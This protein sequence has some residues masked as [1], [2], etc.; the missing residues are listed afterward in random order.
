MNQMYEQK[1]LKYKAKYLQLKAELE[2]GLSMPKMSMPSFGTKVPE[3][4]EVA[5]LKTKRANVVQKIA[6]LKE[7]ISAQAAKD[8]AEAKLAAANSSVESAKQK[9]ADE[10]AARQAKKQAVGS[11]GSAVA[12]GGVWNPF[13]KGGPKSEA[14]KALEDKLEEQQKKLKTIDDEINA[15]LKL[16]KAKFEVEVANRKQESA[17]QKAQDQKAA[18]HA[19]APSTPTADPSA[20]PAAFWR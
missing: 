12:M 8:A 1:Y 5:A 13:S 14:L 18:R 7:Q 10:K 19:S 20:A 15:Q 11:N 3:S 9:A 6:T 4:P 2:G 17:N 16:D